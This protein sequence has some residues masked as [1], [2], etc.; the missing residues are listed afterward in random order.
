MRGICYFNSK[1]LESFFHPSIELSLN[2]PTRSIRAGDLAQKR[3]HGTFDLVDAP[4]LE[5]APNARL[6]IL[7]LAQFRADLLQDPADAIGVLRIGDADR[8]RRIADAAVG[9]VDR[10]DC[11]ERDDMDR[12]VA[13]S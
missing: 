7:V 9:V 1:F 10:R 5:I 6:E 2:A 13:R 12:P 8:D 11:A 4:K 3:D